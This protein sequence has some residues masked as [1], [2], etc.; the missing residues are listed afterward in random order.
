MNFFNIFL[1]TFTVEINK[2]KI[3]NNG[4]EVAKSDILKYPENENIYV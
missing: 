4:F 1:Y 2:L 3:K